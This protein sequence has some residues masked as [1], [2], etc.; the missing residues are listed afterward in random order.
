[1]TERSASDRW[2]TPYEVFKPL[3]RDFGFTLDAAAEPENSLVPKFLAP[4][5]SPYTKGGFYPAG[6]FPGQT[7]ACAGKD[8]LKTDWAGE[9]VWCNPPYGRE[10]GEWVLRAY[11][12]VFLVPKPAKLAVLLLPAH[13]GPAWFHAAIWD[14]DING[15][16]RGVQVRFLQGRIKFEG[17]YADG[18]PAR[19][20]S[21][22]V[23]MKS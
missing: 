11:R 22:V 20:D 18:N 15:P 2:W 9:R 8:G 21:M 5:D 23:V 19:F 6:R 12:Q 13:T 10:V 17:P 3:D 14:K 1:M 16:R 7:V 4:P